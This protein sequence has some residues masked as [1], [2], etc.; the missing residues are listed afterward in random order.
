MS[1]PSGESERALEIL[2]A[3]VQ[4][5]K[6]ADRAVNIEADERDIKRAHPELVI[7]LRG[8]AFFKLMRQGDALRAES[9]FLKHTIGV[10]PD[11]ETTGNDFVDTLLARLKA[12]R[13]GI[14]A[15]P[16]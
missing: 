5:G 14:P 6:A 10:Y 13:A 2:T 11:G 15:R 8:H 16:R 7:L 3:M 4:E 1:S 12:R 9:Y